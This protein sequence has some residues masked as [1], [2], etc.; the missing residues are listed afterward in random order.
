MLREPSDRFFALWVL[1]ATTGMRRCEL[2]GSLVDLLDLEA[3]TLD[4]GPTRVVVDGKVIE[5][6]GKTA[7]AQHVLALD[8][9]TVAV[10]TIHV[11]M[12]DRERK[13]FG[14]DYH[15]HGLLFCRE[16]GLPPHPA[17]AL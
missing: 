7:N 1:E 11:E 12:L 16:N 17:L 9:F 2:A 8:P 3:E 10:L 4:F 15:D 14:P 13:E 6:D 5:S